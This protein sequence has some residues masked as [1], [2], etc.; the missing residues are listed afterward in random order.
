MFCVFTVF[1][2]SRCALL[3]ETKRRN[4]F[5]RIIFHLEIWDAQMSLDTYLCSPHEFQVRSGDNPYPSAGDSSPA[6]AG[7]IHRD[8]YAVEVGAPVGHLDVSRPWPYRMDFDSRFL[9]YLSWYF[10]SHT[11]WRISAKAGRINFL[12]LALWFEYFFLFRLFIFLLKALLVV[13]HRFHNI[14]QFGKILINF[15]TS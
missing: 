4:N 15:P 13:N 12:V 3:F 5:G 9:S 14:S 2:P 10:W 7:L 6:R 11:E 8:D 1:L